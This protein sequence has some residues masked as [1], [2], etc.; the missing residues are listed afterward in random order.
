MHLELIFKNAIRKL[1]PSWEKIFVWVNLF[2]KI[3]FVMSSTDAVLLHKNVV[4]GA[5]HTDIA[6]TNYF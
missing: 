5:F 6:T 2:S 1:W 3:F 4:N